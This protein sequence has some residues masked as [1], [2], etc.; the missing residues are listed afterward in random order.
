M[1]EVIVTLL[2]KPGKPADHCASYRPLSLLNQYYKILAKVLATRISLIIGQ[3]ISPYQ[4]GFMPNRSSSVNLRT[5]FA[6]LNQINPA[7]PAI[8]I[9]LDAEKAFD[10]LEWDFLHAA[11]TKL[12]FPQN[13]RSLFR[14]LYT[15]PVAQLRING[16]LSTRFMLS[17]GTWQ[18]CPLSPLLFIIAMDPLVRH[19]QEWH[20]H[21]GNRISSRSFACVICGRH[22]FVR[23]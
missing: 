3:I 5:L 2:L 21:S 9:L 10:S 19:L 7:L 14:L 1:S 16:V 15:S 17:R 4:L 22:S 6:V 20:L 23:P 11:L 18:G 12:G 13:F 8:A